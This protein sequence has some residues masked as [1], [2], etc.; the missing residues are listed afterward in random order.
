[1]EKNTLNMEDIGLVNRS[2]FAVIQLE[3]S[4]ASVLENIDEWIFF[5]CYGSEGASRFMFRNVDD[6]YMRD[7][8]KF[9]RDPDTSLFM[10]KS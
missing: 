1:M 7:V 5:V 3:K 9:L 2:N 6:L 10:L 4:W 8:D